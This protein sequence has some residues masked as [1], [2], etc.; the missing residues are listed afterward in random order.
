M[1]WLLLIPFLLVVL[2]W[3]PLSVRVRYNSRLTVWAG[4]GP[5]LARVYETTGE[6]P[7]P[8]K[9][10]PGQKQDTPKEKKKKKSL[11]P[12]KVNAG[13]VL[14][15]AASLPAPLAK[16]LRRVHIHHT[17]VRILTTGSD[18]AEAAVRAG[19]TS[20]AVYSVYLALGRIFTVDYPELLILPDFFREEDNIY[21][22]SRVTLRPVALLAFGAGF[23]IRL[24]KRRQEREQ[25]NDSSAQA[26]GADPNETE[27]Q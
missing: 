3:L 2:L 13:L 20:A 11:F 4:V 21:A 14:D 24:V 22:E 18:A 27:V 8:P 25:T 23:V 10:E 26:A 12:E 17:A 15:L 19:H 9:P 16:L 6:S 7:E 5:L 1:K